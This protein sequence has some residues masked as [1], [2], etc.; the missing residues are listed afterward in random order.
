ML[1]QLLLKQNDYLGAGGHKGT[2]SK[3]QL[4]FMAYLTYSIPGIQQWH[5]LI[6]ERLGNSITPLT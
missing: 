2:P 3:R 6:A 1:S 5:K 4:S